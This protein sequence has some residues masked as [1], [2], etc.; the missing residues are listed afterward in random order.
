MKIKKSADLAAFLQRAQSCRHDVYFDTAE[1][2][3]LNLK[4]MLSQFVFAAVAGKLDELSYRIVADEEDRE[5]LS[6]YLSEE[7]DG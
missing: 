5:L 7:D 3:H 2:D 6:P 4:S 1:G